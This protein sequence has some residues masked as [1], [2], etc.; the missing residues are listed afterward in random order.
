MGLKNTKVNKNYV[1]ILS[2]GTLRIAVPEGTDGAV[3]R[4]YETSDGKTG[5]KWEMVYTELAGII[6][7]IEFYEGEYGKL[8]QLSV[9][10]DE[11]ETYTLSVQ[12]ASNFGEDIMKK[13]PSLDLNV[14]IK[15]VPYSFEDDKGKKKK[16][17]TIYQ[18]DKKISN[19]FYDE[20]S[21]KNVHGYPNPEIKKG[22]KGKKW[23]KEEWKIYFMNARLF[24]IDYISE[25]LKV[26]TKELSA[27]D[28][29][30]AV[31]KDAES[32]M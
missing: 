4:D 14:A 21:K 12:T 6:T 16:G 23:G 24:L 3:K 10:D 13:L 28:E 29:F 5:T 8:I 2:D 31:V 27:D 22:K 30:E 32:K 7:K 9:T 18:D 20:K 1:T 26:T 17:V 15:I 25:N 19:F 11:G